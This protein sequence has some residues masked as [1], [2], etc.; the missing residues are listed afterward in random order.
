M[1]LHSR[2]LAA[3]VAAGFLALSACTSPSA[4][5]RADLIK[6][7]EGYSLLGIVE[8]EKGAFAD[9]D[10]TS[11]ALHSDEIMFRENY[12]GNR[13]SLLWGTFNFYDN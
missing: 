6:P 2:F 12:S 5:Q 10:E 11:F 13:F 9:H 4:D 1:R 3:F 7:R 8:F